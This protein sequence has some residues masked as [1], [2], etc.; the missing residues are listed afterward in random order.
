[1]TIER[2]EYILKCA[3]KERDEFKHRMEN[4]RP[5][6]SIHMTGPSILSSLQS[7]VLQAEKNVEALL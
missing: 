4:A 2:A 6:D 5:N 3:E 7:K 1:M